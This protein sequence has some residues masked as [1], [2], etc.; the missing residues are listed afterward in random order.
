MPNLP[1]LANMNVSPRTV[2]AL[3]QAGWD[4]VRVSEV[5]L[6]YASDDEILNLA[7]EQTRVIVTQ[8]L[9]F[10]TLLALSGQNRPSLVT[11]RL[12]VSDPDAV[13]A[14]LLDVLPAVEQPL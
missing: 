11:L 7:R 3:R 9:D 12:T 8:D 4:I 10:S 6:A 5:M 1:F 14:K 2:S 13:T